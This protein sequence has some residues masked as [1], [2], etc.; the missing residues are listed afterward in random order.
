[1]HV[2]DFDYDG[3]GFVVTEEATERGL[4]RLWDGV[5]AGSVGRVGFLAGVSCR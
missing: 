4:A 5:F 3:V 1:M 2:G